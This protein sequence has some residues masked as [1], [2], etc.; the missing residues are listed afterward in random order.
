MIPVKT[1]PG[2][3]W[4]GHKGQFWRGWIQVWCIWYI[5][6]AKIVSPPSITIKKKIKKIRS[7]EKWGNEGNKRV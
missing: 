5:V 7:K 3:G 1:V 4:G 2:L 6:N